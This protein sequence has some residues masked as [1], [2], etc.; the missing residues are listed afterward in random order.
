MNQR[1]RRPPVTSSSYG[2]RTCPS[3]RLEGENRFIVAMLD[4]HEHGEAYIRYTVMRGDVMRI[5]RRYPGRRV[6][7]TT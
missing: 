5:Y 7:W 2:F 3:P 6:P 4:H 1:A